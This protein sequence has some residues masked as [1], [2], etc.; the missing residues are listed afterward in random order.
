MK[1]FQKN[2]ITSNQASPVADR[3]VLTVPEFCDRWHVSTR[4]VSRWL[5]IGLPHMKFSYRNL[6]IPVPEADRWVEGN[7]KRQ[8]EG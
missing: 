1:N 3:L 6:K 7:F 8:R 4:T 5:V 2:A